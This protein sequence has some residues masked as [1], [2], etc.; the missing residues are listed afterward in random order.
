[1]PFRRKI[2]EKFVRQLCLKS[3]A[4]MPACESSIARTTHRLPAV[5]ILRQILDTSSITSALACQRPDRDP[6]SR[7]LP[8]RDLSRD[9]GQRFKEA[10]RQGFNMPGGARLLRRFGV[11][12]GLQCTSRARLNP[13]LTRKRL[14][15]FRDRD[16]S[17]CELGWRWLDVHATRA[18]M[19]AHTPCRSTRPRQCRGRVNG[20]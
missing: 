2:V 9:Y 8:C 12:I 4:N 5:R 19:P 3:S 1:M 10:N 16:G 7:T 14:K 13:F 17:K 11:T 18:P 20:N 15:A 6:A